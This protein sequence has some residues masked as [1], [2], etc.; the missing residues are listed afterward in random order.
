MSVRVRLAQPSPPPGPGAITAATRAR[1]GT[2]RVAMAASLAGSRADSRAQPPPA[3]EHQGAR[4]PGLKVQYP[5]PAGRDGDTSH[6]LSPQRADPRRT[7]LRP[8]IPGCRTLVL[9]AHV[10]KHLHTRSSADEQDLMRPLIAIDRERCPRV[11]GQRPELGRLRGRTKD[12]LIT[13]PVKPD[14]DDPGTT[15]HPGV[16]QPRRVSRPQQGLRN[17]IIEQFETALPCHLNPSLD[18]WNSDLRSGGVTGPPPT[19]TGPPGRALRPLP[20][21]DPLAAFQDDRAAQSAQATAEG[22]NETNQS[23]RMDQR[24]PIR[25]GSRGRCKI[26]C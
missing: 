21:K 12:K 24:L 13:G 5:D 16:G 20:G 23:H 6:G 10:I 7:L 8:E 15:I 9:R 2:V 14:R 1:L 18:D 22:L 25:P 11:R 19:C 26:V 17:R 3:L 4:E